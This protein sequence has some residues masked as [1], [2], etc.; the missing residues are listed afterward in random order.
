LTEANTAG[1]VNTEDFVDGDSSNVDSHT[2]HGTSSNFTAQ[3]DSN[4]AYNDTL[5]EADTNGGGTYLEELWVTGFTSTEL[6]WTET[7]GSPYLGAIDYATNY[8]YTSTRSIYESRFT[9]ADSAQSATNTLSTVQVCIY[10][11]SAGDDQ[12][13]V[14]VW[15]GSANTVIGSVT[16]TT[17]WTWY[18][19]TCTTT[20]N[21]WAK[22]QASA[23]RVRSI[24]TGTT[25]SQVRVDASLIRVTSTRAYNYEMD[26]EFN[27]TVAD[28][29]QTNEYLCIRTYTF[30]GTAENLKVDVWSGGA[31]VNLIASLTANAWN[32]VS[33]SSNLTSANIYFRF[34]G[35]SE[36]SDSSQNTWTIEC[37]LIH[38]W[39]DP[40]YEL[41]LEVQWTNANYD[42]A[43]KW[44]C[45]YGGTMGIENISVYVWSGTDWIRV[46]EYLERGWNNADV[47]SYLTSS[48]F[49]IRFTGG[50]ETGDVTEDEW[51]IDATFLH[52]W[53]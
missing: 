43:Y 14:S 52:T 20:L 28:W 10:A 22:V 42:E 19:Q 46:L 8:I 49:K 38:Y 9:Y 34:L 6:D 48:T 1:T 17:T 11:Y 47:S 51:E 3:K 39:P 2:G 31:W 24:R 25:M 7:G 32:N 23:L 50:T 15:D 26:K 36:A 18:N 33:I 12:I 35:A 37:S 4:I 16:P 27:Y 44:L 21:T 30:T 40:N 5:T 53:S 29:G 13:E 45:I 41:D